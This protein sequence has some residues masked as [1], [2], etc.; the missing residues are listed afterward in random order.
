MPISSRTPV[1]RTAALVVSRGESYESMMKDGLCVNGPNKGRYIEMKGDHMRA[2]KHPVVLTA[3]VD[4]KPP[5]YIEMV[6]YRKL[7]RRNGL[8][9]YYCWEC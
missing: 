8:H 5:K 7:W 9:D 1:N 3:S 2:D 4:D 6:I